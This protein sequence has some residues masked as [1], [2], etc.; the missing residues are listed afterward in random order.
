[1]RQADL[2]VL[3]LSVVYREALD[4]AAEISERAEPEAAADLDQESQEVSLE[5]G[6][7]VAA[8]SAV[9]GAQELSSSVLQ[10]WA[11]GFLSSPKKGLVATPYG[12]VRGSLWESGPIRTLSLGSVAAELAD[13]H[14]TSWVVHQDGDVTPGHQGPRVGLRRTPS[15]AGVLKRIG[16]TV[17]SLIFS[18]R[19]CGGL[20]A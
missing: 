6:A 4:T 8:T 12:K 20:Q 16:M 19:A 3:P 15:C 17:R 11:T 7:L 18:A 5:V 1:M 9:G 2:P 14:W 10:A 13:A